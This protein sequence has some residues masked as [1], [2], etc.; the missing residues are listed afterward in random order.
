MSGT[1]KVPDIP[2]KTGLIATVGVARAPSLYP[3]AL[4]CRSCLGAINKT[5][6]DTYAFVEGGS[7]PTVK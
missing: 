7:L 5:C 2:I 4:F 1:E 3:H 6:V